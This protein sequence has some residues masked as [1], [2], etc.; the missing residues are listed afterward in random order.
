MRDLQHVESASAFRST[1][2][3]AHSG[4][5]SASG[6]RTVGWP[7]RPN[8][9]LKRR[10][11]MRARIVNRRQALFFGNAPRDYEGVTVQRIDAAILSAR[12]EL[13]IEDRFAHLSPTTA[14]NA[15][16]KHARAET[17]RRTIR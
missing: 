2:Q 6:T 1:N 12:I 14:I 8:L 13:V 16:Q 3:R 11:R 4:T 10:S 15:E 9:I 17:L 7:D 5:T